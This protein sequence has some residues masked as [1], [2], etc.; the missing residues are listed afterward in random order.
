MV[1]SSIG[2]LYVFLPAVLFVYYIA[3]RRC[4]NSIL[5]VFSLAFY[6][7]G[8]QKLVIIMLFS[9]LT[10]YC[11]SIFIERFRNRKAITRIFLCLSLIVNLSLLGYFKY[12]DLFIS[13][14]NGVFGTALPL[15]KIAL[16]IGISFYTFQTMS[17]TI[18][19][20]R[21]DIKAEKNFIS[22]TTY[23][24]L[25]PQLIAGP[26]VRY[27]TIA[28]EL[29]DRKTTLDGFASGI[30]RFCVGLGKK[31]LIANTLAGLSQMYD[32]ANTH[33]VL[34]AWVCAIAVPLQIY[35]DFSGYSDMAIGLGRMFGFNFPENFNYPFVSRSATEF[36]RRWHI[37]LGT[38]F[39]D[40][41][42]IP[43]GGN[44]VNPTRHIFNLLVVWFATG[45]WHGA[46]YNFIL[47][48]LYY[49]VLLTAEKFLYIK[50]LEKSELFSHIYFIL[51]TVTGFEIFSANSLAD[52]AK[53][54][55]ELVGIGAAGFT[56]T[57]SSYYSLSYLT[58]LIIAVVLSVP[59][60]KNLM[61]KF[62]KH[63]YFNA[64]YKYS[65]YAACIG[66]LIISTAYLID[67]SYNPFLYFRF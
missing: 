57:E 28:C 53:R 9:A 1:F 50:H 45:L 59:L 24:T 55:G 3:P 38:W 51:I 63:R 22:F 41:V 43:M 2:F 23:V 10:D 8:E 66:L 11:C 19:V 67:G 13:S 54:F 32:K 56:N 58:V 34:F 4:R 12:A 47:W 15:L 30:R 26:I 60:L 29:H 36:W 31:V 62:E 52:I 65:A 14:F 42:Y 18:D 7:I 40:Y 33:T 49:G 48:G 16:P 37:T 64:T 39:K 6:Y 25:F 35:F 46:A 21:G 44:R 20:Y 27:E 17:Y 61:N 5:L